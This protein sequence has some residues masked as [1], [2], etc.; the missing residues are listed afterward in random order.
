MQDDPKQNPDELPTSAEKPTTRQTEADQ[1]QTT[2]DALSDLGKISQVAQLKN[3]KGLLGLVVAGVVVVFILF[4][5]FSNHHK[6]TSTPVASNVVGDNDS[7]IIANNAEQLAGLRNAQNNAFQTPTFQMNTGDQESKAW[8]ARKNAP[9]QMYNA[10]LPGVSANEKPS[11]TQAVFAGGGAF[12][13]FANDQSNGAPTVTGKRILHPYDTIAQGEFIHATLETAIN[14]EL[15]GMVRAVVSQPV[16]AYLGQRPL[17]PAGSRLIGQYTALAGNGSAS[18][19]VFVVWNRIITP[20]GI[21]IMINSPGADRLGR[22]GMGAD[23]VNEHFWKIF[24]TASLLSVMGAATANGGVGSYDQPN[25][26]DMYR[27]SIASAF[28]QSAQTMLSQDLNIKPTLYIHQ[29]D[30]VTVFVARDVDLYS[31]LN[32]AQA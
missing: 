29:G 7:N 14:S 24:G 21:S 5:S 8:L 32:Q 10:P 31:A 12:S 2:D 13:K 25:S 3:H 9:T 4:V 6:T 23:A 19:R 18:T 27:Q 26:A 15:P 11:A 16:Y 22:A 17:I 30:T 28:A 1:N 20:S